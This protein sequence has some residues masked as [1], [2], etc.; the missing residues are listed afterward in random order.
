MIGV[1]WKHDNVY[2]DTS[3]CLP[4]YYPPPL[5]QL[6]RTYGQDKVLFGTNFPWLPFDKYM[7]EV[8]DLDLPPDVENKFLFANA[9][10]VFRLDAA[11]AAPA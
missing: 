2:I 7:R 8:R 3:A 5:L 11:A 1:A 4:G 10:S 6:L 9:R